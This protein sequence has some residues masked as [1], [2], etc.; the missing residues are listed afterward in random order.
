MV[1]LGY[2]RRCHR[3]SILYS[4][5]AFPSYLSDHG[6]SPFA[7][8]QQDYTVNILVPRVPGGHKVSQVYDHLEFQSSPLLVGMTDHEPPPSK[9][10][11]VGD[12]LRWTL[13]K[14]HAKENC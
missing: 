4:L 6:K 14:D 9:S 3:C 11:F 10:D 12:M 8:A 5:T 1:S 2:F 7:L 13:F